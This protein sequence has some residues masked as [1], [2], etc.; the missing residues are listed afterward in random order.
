MRVGSPLPVFSI[1][2]A[3]PVTNRFLLD[4]MG[5]GGFVRRMEEEWFPVQ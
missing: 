4:L 2:G 3:K 5:G 1:Y